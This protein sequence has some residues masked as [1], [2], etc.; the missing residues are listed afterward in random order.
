MRLTAFELFRY[1]LPLTEPLPLAAGTLH[2]REGILLRLAGDGGEEGWSEASPLPGFSR[3]SQEEV[4]EEL[5]ELGKSLMRREVSPDWLNPDGEPSRELDHLS[6]APSAR[7]GL[8]LAIWNLLSATS[9]KTMLEMLPRRPAETVW[10]N[11]LLSGSPQE[12]LR[13]A[14]RMRDAGYRAVKLKVGRQTVE[15]DAEL[16]RAVSEMLS[17]SVSLRLDANRAWSLEDAASFARAT[18][19]LR[20]EYIEEPLADA[21]LLPRF[22]S[23]TGAPVAL[24]ESLVG[25]EPEDL[26]SHGYARAVVLK[27]TLLGGISRTLRLAGRAG[28]LGITPVISSAYETGIGTLGL[29]SLAAAVVGNAPAGLDTYRRLAG[30][31]LMP[32]LDLSVPRVDVR[33]ALSVTREVERDRLDLIARL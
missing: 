20:Y 1:S 2:S 12:V 16:V 9:G 5:R 32:P 27:P 13:D 24:D 26:S 10:L 11:G 18:Q 15:K 3:E 22:A 33:A 30:D 8:E 6:L 25:M 19:D 21:A 28:Q 23:E 31:V 4:V 7:F 14:R 17:G 29:I